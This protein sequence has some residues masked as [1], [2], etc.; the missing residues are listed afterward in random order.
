VGAPLGPAW[1][2][3]HP[4]RVQLP[5]RALSRV[6][7]SDQAKLKKLLE[8]KSRTV[9]VRAKGHGKSSKGHGKSKQ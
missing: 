1:R 2:R 7:L 5:R 9:V 3:R 8:R 6:Q 4:A